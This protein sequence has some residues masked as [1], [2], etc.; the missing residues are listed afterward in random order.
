MNDWSNPNYMNQSYLNPN[1]QDFGA[2]WGPQPVPLFSS[3]AALPDISKNFLP[4]M[5]QVA[6]PYAS[7]MGPMMDNG[8]V[9]QGLG[10]A[11]SK[12][13]AGSGGNWFSNLFKGAVGTKD[14][15]GWG[16][17]ALQGLGGAASLYMGMKQ[18]GL[19]KETL[20]EN[21]RQFGLEYDAQ[22]TTTNSRLEDRQ[23]A[24]VASNSGAYQSVGDYMNQNRIK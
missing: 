17:L 10:D 23:R 24:R 7:P 18:Y 8:V 2:G 6:M 13:E 12:F 19:A 11:F 20:A 21:K 3:P 9:G 4:A 16:G 22:K 14:Q 1:L 5:P 15:P